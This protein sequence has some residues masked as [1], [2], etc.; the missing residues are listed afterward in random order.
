MITIIFAIFFLWIHIE[1]K[2]LVIDYNSL[3]SPDNQSF[4]VLLEYLQ[5]HR[6]FT[7]QVPDER[8]RIH[9]IT[10]YVDSISSRRLRVG[11]TVRVHRKSIY[12]FGKSEIISSIDSNTRESIPHQSLYYILGIGIIFFFSSFAIGSIALWFS[13]KE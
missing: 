9:E 10:E 7:Y 13:K 11:D 12:S 2:Q 4:A 6:K 8:G 5:K 3:R 1:R